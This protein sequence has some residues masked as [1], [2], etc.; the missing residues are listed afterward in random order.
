V[1]LNLVE[2]LLL[3]LEAHRQLIRVL[4]RHSELAFGDTM[5][6]E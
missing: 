6:L 5:L 4:H 3:L 1:I 2:Q